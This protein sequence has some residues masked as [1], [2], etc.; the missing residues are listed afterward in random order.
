MEPKKG[1]LRY[2][3]SITRREYGSGDWETA[4]PTKQT[5]SPTYWRARAATMRAL[6]LCMENAGTKAGMAKLAADYDKRADRTEARGRGNRSNRSTPPKRVT[7]PKHSF[8]D[9]RT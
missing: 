2:P 8:P 1:T 5:E 4:L 3:G 9:A 6:M 7:P